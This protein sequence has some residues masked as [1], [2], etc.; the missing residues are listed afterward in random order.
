MKKEED[1]LATP[2]G[3][4]PQD[5]P[6]EEIKS[7]PKANPKHV[8][9][10][11][12]SIAAAYPPHY[13]TDKKLSSSKIQGLEAPEIIEEVA[14]H[15]ISPA[16]PVS[17]SRAGVNPPR[18]P[19]SKAY[20]S[21]VKMKADRGPSAELLEVIKA[22]KYSKEY[23]ENQRK[24]QIGLSTLVGPRRETTII[25]LGAETGGQAQFERQQSLD[26]NEQ[27]PNMDILLNTIDKNTSLKV[28]LEKAII[29]FNQDPSKAFDFLWKEQIVSITFGNNIKI[30]RKRT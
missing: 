14:I 22:R 21:G 11:E 29:E 16:E 30:A 18:S 23:F 24:E 28:K 9:I 12:V 25:K 5:T 6:H 2:S 19:T 8:A 13:P 15:G 7:V 3:D 27:I 26:S 10:A 4:H 20:K 1:N 17:P